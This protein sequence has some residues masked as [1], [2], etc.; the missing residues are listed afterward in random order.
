M[1]KLKLFQ[2][3]II[4]SL[5]LVFTIGSATSVFSA[6]L[7]VGTLSCK[8]WTEDRTTDTNYIN[9]SV[10]QNWVIGFLTAYSE[11]TRTNFLV[12]VQEKDIYR[13]IDKYC[14]NHPVKKIDDVSLTLAH[15][16]AQEMKTKPKP[17]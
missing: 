16:L 4:G 15:E 1:K 7:A 14:A 11:A 6:D 10:D 3:K 13:W 8:E 9:K 17:E 2:I 12:G 5:L